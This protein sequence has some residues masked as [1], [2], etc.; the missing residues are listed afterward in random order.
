[1]RFAA[2]GFSTI[3]AAETKTWGIGLNQTI[4]A[5]NADFYLHFRDFKGSATVNT[6]NQNQERFVDVNVSPKD[7]QAVMTGMIVRF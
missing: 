3:K 1:V 2:D 4:D 5:A 6:F 7:F